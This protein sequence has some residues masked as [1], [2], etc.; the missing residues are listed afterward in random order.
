MNTA[1]LFS[2]AAAA[3]AAAATAAAAAAAAEAA[4]P[5]SLVVSLVVSLVACSPDGGCGLDCVNA[6]WYKELPQ[7]EEG[8]GIDTI[9][10]PR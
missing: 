10:W 3:A 1:Q 5:I 2:I 8:G 6:R 9:S 7:P 4:V